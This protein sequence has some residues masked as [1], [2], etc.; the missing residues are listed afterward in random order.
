MSKSDNTDLLNQYPHQG[1]PELGCHCAMVHGSWMEE[2]RSAAHRRSIEG[3]QASLSMQDLGSHQQMVGLLLKRSGEME[4][5]EAQAG[6]QRVQ[7]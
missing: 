6:P 2:F 5:W 3:P 1:P 4:D 7:R